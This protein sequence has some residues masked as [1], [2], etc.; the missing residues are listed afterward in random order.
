MAK[1][2][3]KTRNKFIAVYEFYGDLVYKLKRI[4]SSIIFSSQF[5]EIISNYKKIGYI[6][7]VLQQTACLVVNPITLGN[8]A[9]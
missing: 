1:L 8:F 4:V 5:I 6:I 3:L 9:L 7:N 2:A